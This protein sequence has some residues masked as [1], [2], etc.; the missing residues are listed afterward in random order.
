MI[1]SAYKEFE[2][3]AGS[4]KP[5]RGAKTDLVA[6][7]IMRQN[8]EFAMSDIEKECAGISR[9]MIR[10]VLDGL[11]KQKKVEVLGTGRSAKWRKR[12]NK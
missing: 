6:A 7:A 9:P 10:V 4:V 2:Q 8:G 5:S 12:D 11:R 3:R 1:L